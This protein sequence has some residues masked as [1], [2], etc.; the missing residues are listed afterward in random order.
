MFCGY[1]MGFTSSGDES[2]SEQIL[3]GSRTARRSNL[4]ADHNFVN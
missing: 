1:V 4:E 2:D 3:P